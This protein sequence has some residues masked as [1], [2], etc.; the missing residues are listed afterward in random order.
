MSNKWKKIIIGV[1][2]LIG[3]VLYTQYDKRAEPAWKVNSD[4][5]HIVSD[6]DELMDMEKLKYN[7]LRFVD[8]FKLLKDSQISIPI[9]NEQRKMH[10]ERTWSHGHQMYIL[11]SVDLL[12]RDKDEFEVPRLFVEKI[13]LSSKKGKDFDLPVDLFPGETSNNGMVYKHKLYRSIMI[14][15]LF[16]GLT[17]QED[18][19]EVLSSERYELSDLSVSSKKNITKLKPIAFKVNP[20]SNIL[21]PHTIDSVNLNQTL[22]IQDHEPLQ[23]K[24]LEFFQIG[25]RITLSTNIDKDLVSL[26]GI[27]KKNDIDYPVDLEI[28]GDD[29]SGY[30][31][32]MYAVE[33][34]LISQEK[35][36]QLD[37]VLTHYVQ[38]KPDLYSFSVASSDLEKFA[39]DSSKDIE[40]N[41]II[42]DEKSLKIV[43]R[44][45]AM[46]Q[47]NKEIGIKFTLDD[48]Q[49]GVEDYNLY[50]QPL[51][52]FGEKPGEERHVRNIV[53]VKDSS[54]KELQNFDIMNYYED[55][56][57]SFLIVFHDGLPKENL[58]ITFSHLTHI[59]P[60]QKQ[61]IIPL[62]LPS[63]K[64]K[65]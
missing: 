9:P 27:L 43:Y 59:A 65:K 17:S 56:K 13:K 64:A 32:Q 6:W 34:E 38:R 55:D 35:D 31:L 25:S 49:E 11:Y 10:I 18:W 44:G 5:F 7:E 54:G 62:K 46:E 58:S 26:A 63:I 57:P 47:D 42:A 52:H 48:N 15:P 33:N 36:D 16:D 30:F 3:F 40:K 2:L 24:N 60:L 50:P 22:S 45:L 23:L 12:E 19:D 4:Q 53:S 20:T 8:H 1:L 14:H 21:K 39:I 37:L 29:L 41:E 61:V 28:N 51:Y